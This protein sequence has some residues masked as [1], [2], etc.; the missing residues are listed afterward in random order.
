MV[1]ADGLL[2]LRKLQF[3]A[4][5]EQARGMTRAS[6]IRAWAKDHIRLTERL[7]HKE[8]HDENVRLLDVDTLAKQADAAVQGE[9]KCA[10][11]QQQ[12][13]GFRTKQHGAIF[14]LT[15]ICQRCQ[16]GQELSLTE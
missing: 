9:M 5:H 2:S 11:C 1:M 7:Y 3:R 10:R 14:Q 6:L 4:I 15:G 16:D 13:T 12:P 8:Q